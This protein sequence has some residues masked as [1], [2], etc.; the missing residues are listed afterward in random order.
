MIAKKCNC[1]ILSSHISVDGRKVLVNIDRNSKK[2]SLIS[3]YA[4]NPANDINT[5]LDKTNT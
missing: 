4:P 1:N 5:F 3:L 2:S